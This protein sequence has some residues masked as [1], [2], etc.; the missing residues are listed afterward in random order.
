MIS[1]YKNIGLYESVFFNLEMNKADFVEY[2]NKITYKTNTT[3]ISFVPDYGIP[4]RFEYRGNV[5]TDNFT[6]KRRLH[7]FDFNIFHSIIKAHITDNNNTIEIKMEF[8]PFI[9][10]FLTLIFGSLFSLFIVFQIIKNENNYL[11]ITIPIIMVI[12]QY[13]VLKRSLKR[14]KYDFIR[15]LNLISTKNNQFKNLK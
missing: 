12:I 2:L 3:F 13:F 4:T 9:L 1:F 14:D 7:L 5:N 8:A 15:E 11:I 6:I 10:H